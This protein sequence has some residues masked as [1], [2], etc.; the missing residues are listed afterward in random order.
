MAEIRPKVMQAK[1]KSIDFQKGRPGVALSL[2]DSEAQPM[3]W[4]LGL[5]HHVIG[6]LT[7]MFS[8]AP[9]L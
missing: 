9:P 4:A 5:V 6:S 2:L 3:S 7:A 1:R 8:L